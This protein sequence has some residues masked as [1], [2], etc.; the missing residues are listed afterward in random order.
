MCPAEGQGIFYTEK[1]IGYESG[2]RCLMAEFSHLCAFG[3][4][5]DCKQCPTGAVCPGGYRLFS[6]PGYWT[7]SEDSGTTVRC[8]PPSTE[9]CQGWNATIGESQCGDGYMMGSFGCMSCDSGFYEDSIKKCEKCPET[10]SSHEKYLPFVYL[11]MGLVT[12]FLFTLL[13]IFI[14]IKIKGG[15]FGE[16]VRRSKDFVIFA[17]VLLQV[18]VS[19][20]QFAQAGLPSTVANMYAILGALNLNVPLLNPSCLSTDPFAGPISRLGISLGVL[21]FVFILIIIAKFG[22]SKTVKKIR[23]FRRWSTLWLALL[24]PLVCTES[25]KMVMFTTAYGDLRL[26]SNPSFIYM[27]P[28]HLRAGIMGWVVFVIHCVGFPLLSYLHLRRIVKKDESEMTN[29]K[30]WSFFI[31]GTF[32]REFFWFRHVTFI[33]LFLT[34]FA[35]LYFNDPTIT[36]NAL[37]VLLELVA[38][39]LM[40]RLLFKCKP[41]RSVKKWMFPVKIYSLFLCCLAMLVNVFCFMLDM[42]PQWQP[43]VTIS[44]WI[45]FCGSILLFLMLIYFFLTYVSKNVID[46]SKLPSKQ[47]KFHVSKSGFVANPLLNRKGGSTRTTGGDINIIDL[48]SSN[49]NHNGNG[50]SSTPACDDGKDVKSGTGIDNHHIFTNSN[51]ATSFNPLANRRNGAISSI[52]ISSSTN[53][54][55]DN[56]NNVSINPIASRNARNGLPINQN[57]LNH[58]ISP[59]SSKDSGAFASA[60]IGN[61]SSGVSLNPLSSRRNG[62]NTSK[63]SGLSSRRPITKFARKGGNNG[64]NNV[65]IEST[66]KSKNSMTSFM[67]KRNNGSVHKNPLVT[68]RM[69]KQRMKDSKRRF[70]RVV[71]TRSIRNLDISSIPQQSQPVT[72][73]GGIGTDV[74]NDSGVRNDVTTQQQFNTLEQFQYNC[75]PLNNDVYPSSPLSQQPVSP[76]S[77]SSLNLG[78]IPSKKKRPMV[79]MSPVMEGTDN[80]VETSQKRRSHVLNVIEY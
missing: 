65:I 78:R 18:F 19:I 74:S 55:F 63:G 37:K 77:V 75:N 10:Q 8:Q 42:S 9:R 64:G 53:G 56:A 24:Y 5:D 44:S 23:N 50:G 60:I 31:G 80:S 71:S 28:D 73:I 4:A 48:S 36:D 57:Q 27:G 66:N 43:L 61:N 35:N 15:R 7:E 21:T 22:S 45:L 29:Y 72:N 1:C 49:G 3:A 14:A 68:K 39:S 58:P 20:G 13:I 46:S 69:K 62:K 25:M 67:G 52:P 17:L 34:S 54:F 30:Q 51:N 6:L 33:F 11:F 70:E 38:L 76:L 41:Y 16:G 40:I 59:S 47:V 2:A 32:E 26:R 12:V 79:V